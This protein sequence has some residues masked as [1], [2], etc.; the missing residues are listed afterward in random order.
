M[1]LTNHMGGGISLNHCRALIIPQSVGG[2]EPLSN[3]EIYGY[4]VLC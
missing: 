3:L 1:R 4:P 2:V